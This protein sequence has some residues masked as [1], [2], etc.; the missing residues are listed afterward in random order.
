MSF[1]TSP[2][3]QT[4][5]QQILTHSRLSCFRDCPRKHL[6]RYELG[7]R[8]ERDS[9]A[10]RFGSAI[11]LALEI[12]DG[13]KAFYDAINKAILYVE[14]EYEQMSVAA[15][16]AAYWDRYDGTGL[17]MVAV[18]QEFDLPLVNPETGRASQNFRLRGKIDGICELPDGRLA[19]VER[20]TT[21]R[22]FSPGADYWTRLHLDQQLSIYVI[23]A[24]EIGYDVQ[25]VLYDVIRRPALRPLMATPP[26]N[27]KYKKDGTLYAS[28]RD[29]DET[30]EEYAVRIRQ[31][32]DARPDH[33]FARH[34]VAR[35]DQ[36]LDDCRAELWMQQQTLRAMQTSGRWYR[37][38]NACFGLFK[39][40]YLPICQN[41]DLD[42]RT[43]QGFVRELNVHPELSGDA[44][45]AG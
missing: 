14:D 34:E 30:P 39:C 11:H 42:T 27:R 23:A 7:L 29:V 35:L 26:E 37:N 2:A 31:D 43:P 21:S 13:G 22:D 16:L 36:D 15:T 45:D 44:T 28:Q 20:K 4:K 40:D 33:Y 25:T 18:E 6:L 3:L 5:Q 1:E 24:R 10:I 38:P 19:L 8:A 9:E 41:N 17:E 12:M 32:I